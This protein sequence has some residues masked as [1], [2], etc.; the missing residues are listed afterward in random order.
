[1]IDR[2]SM[3]S[4]VCA[5]ALFAACGRVALD[6]PEGDVPT[7]AATV[8]AG[9]EAAVSNAATTTLQGIWSGELPVS[10]PGFAWGP[11]DRLTLSFDASYALTGQQW[12]AHIAPP[13]TFGPDAPAYPQQGTRDVPLVPGSLFPVHV[14]VLTA[15]FASDHFHMR[16]R[17]EGLS[18]T[19]KTDYVEDTSGQITGDKLHV[20]YA[21]D[22]TL[23]IAPIA[24]RASGDLQHN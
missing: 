13:H 14:T 2:S 8:D 15:D 23:L 9:I 21:L 3:V 19:P 11:F 6:D 1:M 18:D 16:Y 17:V 10:A 5:A 22:G 4:F 20:V 12:G 24:A 7:T